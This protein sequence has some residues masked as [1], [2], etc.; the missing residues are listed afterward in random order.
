M[1]SAVEADLKQLDFIFAVYRRMDPVIDTSEIAKEMDTLNA[2]IAKQEASI[3]AQQKQLT[4][5]LNQANQILQELP[6][7]LK[8]MDELYSAITGSTSSLR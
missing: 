1:Q 3:A 8:G 5:E 6:N 2:Q 7:Q 4:A